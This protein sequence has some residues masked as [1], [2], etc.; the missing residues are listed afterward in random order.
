MAGYVSSYP[1]LW[2]VSDMLS[3]RE[4]GREQREA[5]KGERCVKFGVENASKLIF[6]NALK[7][8]SKEV[9]APSVCRV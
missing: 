9:L 2:S 1:T 8:S 4:G 3:A 5:K 7:A 6:L